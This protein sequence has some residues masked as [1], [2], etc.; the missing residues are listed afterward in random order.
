ME[1]KRMLCLKLRN[2]PK[3]KFR[4]RAIKL[5]ISNLGSAILLPKFK[6]EANLKL[7]NAVPQVNYYPNL[8]LGQ[9]WIWDT[10]CPKLTIVPIKIRANLKLRNAVP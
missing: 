2:R 9:I 3:L 4:F 6:I 5:K 10:W 8:K 1:W 7:R